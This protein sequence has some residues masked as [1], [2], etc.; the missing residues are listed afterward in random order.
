AALRQHAGLGGARL[1][2]ARR[3]RLRHPRRRETA[4]AAD[5]A[6]SPRAGARR[7]DRGPRHRQGGGPDPGAGPRAP[8][9]RPTPPALLLFG[10]G[11]PAALVPLLVDTRLWPIGLTFFG[12]ALLLLGVDAILAPAPRAFAPTIRAPAALYLGED[13]MLALDLALPSGRFA[14]G[15]EA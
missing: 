10:L 8:M 6:P 9:I 13:D 5:P 7:R 1:R 2:R 15:V 12:A 14:V 11:V 3:A 4:G